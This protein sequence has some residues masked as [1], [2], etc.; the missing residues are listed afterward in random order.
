MNDKE[1]IEQKYQ[2]KLEA[3][4]ADVAKLKAQ[5]KAANAE[6][7]LAIGRRLDE[8]EKQR[9]AAAGKLRELRESG[10]EA[11]VELQRG[12]ERSFNELANGIKSAAAALKGDRV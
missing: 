5:A 9:D 8:L 1:A 6:S 3:W 11:V 10:G 2:A 12:L 7:R 4:R